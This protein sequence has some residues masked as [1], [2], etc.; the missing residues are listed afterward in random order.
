MKTV[1]RFLCHSH[2]LCSVPL[3]L[4]CTPD[5][6]LAGTWGWDTLEGLA[7]QLSHPGEAGRR[8]P[9]GPTVIPAPGPWQ[10]AQLP[11]QSVTRPKGRVASGKTSRF[12]LRSLSA[13]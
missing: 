2:E 5:F 11:L 3:S 9:E 7:A 13:V 10:P 4:L 1:A 6:S 12:Q 8:G